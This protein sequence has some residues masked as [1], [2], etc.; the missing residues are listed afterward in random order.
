MITHDKDKIIISG[1]D[2]A[3]YCTWDEILE[4]GLKHGLIVKKQISK[5]DI[6]EYESKDYLPY[7]SKINK[8]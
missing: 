5:K 6:I 4:Y 3:T 7:K 1:D 2:G 8:K